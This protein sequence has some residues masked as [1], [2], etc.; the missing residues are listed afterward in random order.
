M[1]AGSLVG[2]EEI[3]AEVEGAGEISFFDS[4]SSSSL[5]NLYL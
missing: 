2:L 4:S 5:N 1:G 3:G